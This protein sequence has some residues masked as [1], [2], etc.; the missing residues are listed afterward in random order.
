LDGFF[1]SYLG[2]NICEQLEAADWLT[3]PFQKLR[4]IV[5]GAVF[6]DDLELEQTR[7]RFKWYPHDVW[8]YIMSSVWARIGQEEHL[9]GR[10]GFVEDEIGSAIIGSRLVRDIMR[11][12]FLIEHEYPP[13]PKW[14]GTAFSRL[15]SAKR[16]NPILIEVMHTKSW[17]ERDTHLYLA[18]EIVAELH[19]NLGITETLSPKVT[20]FFKRPFYQINGERFTKALMQQIKDPEVVLIAKRSPIGSIDL[21]S[22]N[23]DLLEDPSLRPILRKLYQLS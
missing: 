6:H 20:Q 2:I 13:Y 3:F 17:Q 15:K 23:P 10:A 14:L 7:S 11:L 8:L 9:M 18:Y 1:S 5:A 12:D 22:D 19:N 4:S 21:L 16:L